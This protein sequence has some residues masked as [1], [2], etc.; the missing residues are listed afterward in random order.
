MG[1]RI[2]IGGVVGAVIL[3]AWGF[4]A[5]VVLP[6]HNAVTGEFQDEAKFRDSVA[7]LGMEPG[8]YVYPRKGMNMSPKTDADKAGHEQW[9]TNFRTG[10]VMM[11]VVREGMQPMAASVFVK[12]FVLNLLSAFLVAGLAAAAIPNFKRCITKILFVA[13]FGLF[14]CLDTHLINWN[15]LFVPLDYTLAYCF[16]SIVAWAIVGIAFSKLF[17]VKKAPAAA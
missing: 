8:V 6:Y 14:S 1:K 9:M 15:W 16:D 12:G 10:P 3:F 13:A 11:L 4:V 5:H 17:E 7:R 2:I